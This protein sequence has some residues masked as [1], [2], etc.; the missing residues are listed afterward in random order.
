MATVI[1]SQIAREEVIESCG[2]PGGLGLQVVQTSEA[3]LDHGQRAVVPESEIT[4]ATS[5]WDLGRKGG[6]GGSPRLP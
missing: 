3:L 2:H 1:A 6:D 4:L 5:Y